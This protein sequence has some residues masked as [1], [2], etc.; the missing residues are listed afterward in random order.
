MVALLSNDSRKMSL[1]KLYMIDDG[2][3]D[4]FIIITSHILVLFHPLSNKAHG[5]H[6]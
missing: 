4:E 6:Q 1:T 2:L 5:C 3:H